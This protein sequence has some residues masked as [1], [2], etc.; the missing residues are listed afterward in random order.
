MRCSHCEF[1]NPAGMQFCGGCGEKLVRICG[2]CEASVPVGFKFCGQCGAEMVSAT[3]APPV[4]LEP[5]QPER[6]ERRQ[7]TVMFCDMVG[8]TEMAGRLDPEDLR[9]VV[10]AYQEATS[11]AISAFGGHIAQHLGDGLL[12][13]FGFP[14]AH[15]DDPRRGIAAALAV[16]R[17]VQDLRG[18]LSHL[19]QELN[20]RIG[21]HTGPVVTGMVGTGQSQEKLALGQTPNIAARLEGIAAPGSVVVSKQ[22]LELAGHNFIYRS[23]GLHSLKGLNEPMEVFQVE[24]ED[25]EPVSGSF[26]R[27]QPPMV[28]REKE[29]NQLL[30]CRRRSLQGNGQTVLLIGPPGVGKSRLL[31]AF[32]HHK[33]L[34]DIRRWNS[35]CS[36]FRQASTLA[37]IVDLLHDTLNIRNDDSALQRLAKI[38]QG[39]ERTSLPQDEA[40]ALFCNLLMVEGVDGIPSH[41]VPPN[42]V[43]E[44]TLEYMHQSI[45]ESL[46]ERPLL[47]CI[48]DLHWADPSTLEFISRLG[49]ECLARPLMVLGTSRV[50]LNLDVPTE[51]FTRVDVE[52]VDQEV[53]ERIV[54]GVTGGKPLPA[55]VVEQIT[56]KTDGVP[57]FIEEFTK[58]LLES[59][60]LQEVDGRFELTVDITGTPLP[61]SLRDSLTARLDRLNESR[62]AAQFASVIGREFTK[63][64]LACIWHQD[65]DVLDAHL[66]AL[67][68]AE[69]LVKVS[70][71]GSG[72]FV[73]KH[74]LIRD[75]AYELLL[76]DTR[77]KLHEKV[78]ETL[79]E[80]FPAQ[81]EVEPEL[82]A[83]HF[84]EARQPANSI[85]YWVKAVQRAQSR[86]AN[87][88][89]THH[90]R[91]GLKQIEAISPSAE[92]DRLEMGLQ[93]PLS[94]S[95]IALQG[96]TSPEVEQTYRRAQELCENLEEAP[97]LF[98]VLM[99]FRN[100]YMVRGD[101]HNAAKI[102]QQ[103]VEM[104][105]TLQ[106]DDL[107]CIA[108]GH[109]G[110]TRMYSG[111]Y[112]AGLELLDI[113]SRCSKRG[114][115]VYQENMG[116]DWNVSQGGVHT[117]CL[118]HL[119]YPDQAYEKSRALL[120]YA[121]SKDHVH[122]L[123]VTLAMAVVQVNFFRR[124]YGSIVQHVEELRL[125][126]KERGGSPMWLNFCLMYEQW[127]KFEIERRENPEGVSQASRELTLKNMRAANDLYQQTTAG[128]SRPVYAAIIVE[129]M[130][131][132]D[133]ADEALVL[134][135]SWI[136]SM[137]EGGMSYM[138]AELTR[139]KAN[140]HVALDE[141]DKAH[142]TFIEGL[143]ISDEQAVKMIGLRTAVDLAQ[144]LQR[145][146]RLEQARQ[147]LEPRLA[148]FRE[149]EASVDLKAARRTL[150]NL[151]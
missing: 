134:A 86:S 117:L 132:L 71:A 127:A 34:Q 125:L 29:L 52:S 40:L 63:Q 38:R 19:A 150:E 68:D 121:R 110:D 14:K 108:K 51:S 123:C 79:I 112:L 21:V 75:A 130:L 11:A 33:D 32:V 97:N 55:E 143:K 114:Q 118:W 77:Q 148:W 145:Q 115:E 104:G 93:I 66:K 17:A 41:D 111:E 102:G 85:P 44:R 25:L 49:R 18:R 94:A 53:A 27:D 12:V 16:L 50:A 2:Q 10:L 106:D 131:K 28:G 99:G 69:L 30:Y 58:N 59:G 8:S 146:N 95:L 46:P 90:C 37:P 61:S 147:T 122:S 128:L 133:Q 109:L 116:L 81:V 126:A 42:Q 83:T 105:T 96:F 35:R 139:L 82:V 64:M 9:S 13:Y 43:M 45:R 151:N 136:E 135:D 36:P 140:A 22:T 137:R 70:D 48:E 62:E 144:L 142:A 54:R 1:E 57:L 107:V 101:M 129:T 65:G 60:L 89:A 84:S 92:R 103:L 74:A 20:V 100:Y 23:L 76:L 26:F 119:G 113:G 67:V 15:E 31:D 87:L 47:I 7:L 88:E 91:S 80:R 3:S 124:E 120:E 24:R 141:F 4:A 6:A 39:V 78:A 73:F 149:G 98:W 138:L 5:S 72:T 56:Y